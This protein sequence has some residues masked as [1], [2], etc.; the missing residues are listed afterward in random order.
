MPNKDRKQTYSSFRE[1]NLQKE[2][3][4]YVKMQVHNYCQIHKFLT[5]WFWKILPMQFLVY[6]SIII[7]VDV[8]MFCFQPI[9]KP[10][11]I[12]LYLICWGIQMNFGEQDEILTRIQESHNDSYNNMLILKSPH[13]TTFL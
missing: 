12:P 5:F 10:F 7:M 13:F 3:N 11:C 8:D 2:L 6:P 4:K 9:A 1:Q